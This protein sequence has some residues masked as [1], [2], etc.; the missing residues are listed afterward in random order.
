MLQ[1]VNRF[2][3][4]NNHP[5]S[6][7]LSWLTKLLP[8]VIATIFL[9]LF[10]C[11]LIANPAAAHHP[12][13][14]TTPTNFFQGFLSGMGHPVVGIDHF[15][16]TIAI[17]LLAALRKPQGVFIPIAFVLATLGGTGLHLMGLDLPFPETVIATS[18]L[19]VGLILGI[20]NN[21]N[22]IG[23]VIAAALAGIFHGYAYGEA[24]VG[25]EMTPLIAYLAG[26][27]FIQLAVALS[28]YQI[29]KIMFKKFA[30]N[31]QLYLR[32]AGFTILGMG[33]AFLF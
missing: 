30:E 9:T 24:I 3:M 18:V 20:T 31:S 8:L 29:S 4:G 15:V 13:G 19:V 25:A 5:Y 33:A 10:N 21:L 1:L 2:F 17:G 28:A 11:L 7:K 12:F 14:G 22:L 23:V 32:F 26:F 6:I 27:A 16:F